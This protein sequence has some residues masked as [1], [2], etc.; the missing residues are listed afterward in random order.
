MKKGDVKKASSLLMCTVFVG[1]LLFFA[2]GYLTVRPDSVSYFENR[3]LAPRP[4]LT[5]N[6]FKD[7]TFAE[8]TE[9]Y[10]S[11]HILMRNALVSLSTEMNYYLGKRSLR[12]VYY[13]S[14]GRLFLKFFRNDSAV[15]R[16]CEEYNAFAGKLDVP[17]DFIL[18]PSAG[19]I[20]SDQLP[21][22]TDCVSCEEQ[23]ISLIKQSLDPGI[24]LICPLDTLRQ[25]AESGVKTYLNT[26]H[27]WT[28]H[29]AKAVMERYL[30][31]IGRPLRRVDY[32]TE[33]VS[34]YYGPMFSNFP[35][36]SIDPEDVEYLTDPE[37]KYTV[38]QPF[39]GETDDKLFYTKYMLE[40]YKYGVFLDCDKG[41]I[42]IHS[43]NAPKGSIMVV[44]D[45]FGLAFMTLLANQYQDIYAVD[46]RHYDKSRESISQL[47]K[48]VGAERVLIINMT[49]SIINS[50]MFG[51]D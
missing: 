46:V 17:V 29:G 50:E 40:W 16:L 30:S 34:G 27:H 20:Y 33:T 25:L 19:M 3:T 6:S 1:F 48:E 45:S 26:D 10:L 36:Y 12:S 43:E 47:T 44:K 2:V 21:A 5:F 39:T 28:V 13:G 51:L 15:T 31:E 23:E 32:K 9:K 42:H 22:G 14:G 4:Q 49:Y 7:G 37:G 8:E 24:D 38:E 41:Y 18:V 35:S 11:D